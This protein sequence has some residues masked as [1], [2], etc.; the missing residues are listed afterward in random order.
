VD[1][2]LATA[3]VGL[4]VAT[5]LLAAACSS[6]SNGSPDPSKNTTSAAA[7]TSGSPTGDKPGS[8]PTTQPT[9]PAPVGP[10]AY[11]TPKKLKPGE[12]PPQFI[13]F[14]FDGVGWHEKWEFWQ[15]IAK[16]VPL[17]FTGFLTGLYLLDEQHKDNYHGP[18][19]GVGKS[20]LGSWNSPADVVQ[21]IK[22]LNK[23][24][25]LGDEIG[26]HFMGHFCSDNP[27]GG[28][29]WSTADW[30]SDL[31]Q[32]FNVYRNHAKMDMIPGMPKLAVPVSSIKGE[33]TPCLE[34][35]TDQL[36]PALR[37]HKM[38]YD[39]SPDRAGI[40][41]PTKAHGIWQMGMADF[42]LAGTDHKVITMDYNFWFAQEQASANVPKAK[43]AQDTAQ[44][45]QT[46][47]DMYGATYNGNRAPLIL[48]NH[49]E[50]WNNNAYT[51]ALANFALKACGKPNTYCVPFI[52]VVR[53]MEA[54]DPHRL[55]QLQAEAPE[56]GPRG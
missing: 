39:S 28:N 43:S 4:T 32:F 3:A 31:D 50:E 45:T 12:K 9:K 8:R 36:F 5:A 6:T 49:F 35:K 22:D 25:S 54:Q 37:A 13:V 41:W 56:T 7:G 15:S 38:I 40:A 51:Q 24:Y 30:N 14:S 27:P 34:G 26:T 47:L 20:S 46:Y 2:R 1:R 23:G 10:A 17:R 52:D 44:I 16:R 29:V 42:P 18:G 11:F 53:W 48:G 19:H 55:A 21:E 33:R